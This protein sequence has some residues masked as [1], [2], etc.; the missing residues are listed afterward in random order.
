LHDSYGLNLISLYGD[1][2]WCGEKRFEFEVFVGTCNRNS[3]KLGDCLSMTELNGI[4]TRFSLVSRFSSASPVHL[5]LQFLAI[6]HFNFKDSSFPL[7]LSF[8]GMVLLVG[9]GMVDWY[10]LSLPR[11]SNGRWVCWLIAWFP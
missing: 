4:L 3:T 9:C 11:L 1:I 5:R 10:V 7:F 6:L 8:L 2:G